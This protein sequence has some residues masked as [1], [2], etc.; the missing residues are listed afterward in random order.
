MIDELVGNL[1]GY[2][3]YMRAKI[4]DMLCRIASAEDR[5]RELEYLVEEIQKKLEA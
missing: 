4:N 2:Q 3:E 5:I 1:E